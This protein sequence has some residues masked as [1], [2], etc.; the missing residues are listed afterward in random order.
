MYLFRREIGGGVAADFKGVNFAAVWPLPDANLVIAIGYI[1]RH[2]KF[3]HLAEGGKHGGRDGIARGGG[4][5][6]L[7]GC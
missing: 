2:E 5:A 6:L 1:L 3:L 4:E 7:V